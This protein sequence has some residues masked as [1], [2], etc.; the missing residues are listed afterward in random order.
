MIVAL[1][2]GLSDGLREFVMLGWVYLVISF[3]L[4]CSKVERMTCYRMVVQIQVR[5]QHV[6][7]MS[8]PAIHSPLVRL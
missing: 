7:H 3:M 5:V 1:I 8:H 4:D 6:R 2:D